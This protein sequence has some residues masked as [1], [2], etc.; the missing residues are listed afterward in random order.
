MQIDFNTDLN[1]K[2]IGEIVP[3]ELFPVGLETFITRTYKCKSKNE[4]IWNTDV[5]HDYA[6]IKEDSDGNKYFYLTY[7]Q[8][9][10]EGK[11]IYKHHFNLLTINDVLK[12][13]TDEVI[14]TSLNIVI[15]LKVKNDN[16]PT[17]KKKLRHSVGD[18][19]I[20]DHNDFYANYEEGC[21]LFIASNEIYYEI[22][23]LF[24]LPTNNIEV[25][26]TEANIDY[27]MNDGK[28]QEVYTCI[29]PNKR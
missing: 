18:Y 11:P 12:N 2:I 19:V 13:N 10:V 26:I 27:G 25:V 16:E 6:E 24:S 28:G 3:E 9:Y 8:K 7:L 15:E 23:N 22:K 14:L 21:P 20:L 5:T 4:D 1:K 29:V 17:K